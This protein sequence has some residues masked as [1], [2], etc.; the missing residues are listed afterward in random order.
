MRFMVRS[1]FCGIELGYQYNCF[2]FK[3]NIRWHLSIT[4]NR[5]TVDYCK[6]PELIY[7]RIIYD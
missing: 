7:I 6:W 3:Y 2:L 5:A 1:L 4:N